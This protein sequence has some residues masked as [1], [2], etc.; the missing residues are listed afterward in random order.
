MEAQREVEVA[1]TLILEPERILDLTCFNNM[2]G[3]AASTTVFGNNLAKDNFGVEKL[4]DYAN[5]VL[6]GAALTCVSMANVW[7]TARCQ[8]FDSGTM[9]YKFEDL[10]AADP[11]PAPSCPGVATRNSN[12]TSAD[13]IVFPPSFRMPVDGGSDPVDPFFDETD[14]TACGAS[15]FLKTGLSA[16]IPDHGTV[17]DG[18]CLA[19]GCYFTGSGCS[20]SGP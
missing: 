17:E 13:L 20:S 18:V 11:R 19:P 10:L 6:S 12:W 3:V 8:N 1:E 16:T 15:F 7:E 14:G 5:E 2:V 9:F 4:Q